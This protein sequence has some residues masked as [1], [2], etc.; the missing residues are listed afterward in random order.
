MARP[1]VQ[2]AELG[3]GIPVVDALLERAHSLFGLDRLGSNDIGYLEVEG[4]V[5]AARNQRVS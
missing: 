3:V 5:L 1:Y 2:R 4:D